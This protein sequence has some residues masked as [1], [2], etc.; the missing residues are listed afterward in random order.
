MHFDALLQFWSGP[1]SAAVYLSDSE[2]SLLTRYID[3]TKM[4]ANRT[5]IALHA[6]YKEG[7][8]FRSSLFPSAFL[9]IFIDKGYS[10]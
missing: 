2:L 9:H 5:N 6:V 8:R 3:D 4:L 7:V 1:V 10:S